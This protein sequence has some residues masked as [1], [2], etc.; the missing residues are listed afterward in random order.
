MLE[1]MSLKFWGKAIFQSDGE[2]AKLS[3]NCEARRLGE[4]ESV[5]PKN[6]LLSLLVNEERGKYELQ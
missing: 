3:V 5:P 2:P 4:L 1:A 6:P